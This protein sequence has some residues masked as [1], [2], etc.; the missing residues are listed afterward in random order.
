M[1]ALARG[2]WVSQRQ[3]RLHGTRQMQKDLILE[4]RSEDTGEYT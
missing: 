4:G 3:A 1:I 2:V